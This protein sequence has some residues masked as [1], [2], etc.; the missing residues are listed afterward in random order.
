MDIPDMAEETLTSECFSAGPTNRHN[1]D[2]EVTKKILIVD[3]DEAI[4]RFYS[5]VLESHGYE[6]LVAE[7]GQHGL[8]TVYR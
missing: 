3:D 7:N 6:V 8:K 2:T 4:Q 5:T 1:G